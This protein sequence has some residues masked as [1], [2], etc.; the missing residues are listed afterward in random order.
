MQLLGTPGRQSMKLPSQICRQR[1][2]DVMTSTVSGYKIYMEEKGVRLM[3]GGERARGRELSYL[4][5]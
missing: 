1:Y 5:E 2:Q 4:T 3:L